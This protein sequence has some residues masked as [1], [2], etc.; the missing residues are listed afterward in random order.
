MASKNYES[1]IQSKGVDKAITVDDIATDVF[2]TGSSITFKSVWNAIRACIRAII[3]RFDDVDTDIQGA[4][5]TLALTNPPSINGNWSCTQKLT[6]TGLT[7]KYTR[8]FFAFYRK[9]SESNVFGIPSLWT[10]NMPDVQFYDQCGAHTDRGFY[11][12]SN[13]SAY[14]VGT[15]NVTREPSVRLRSFKVQSS[16]NSNDITIT[17]ECDGYN[18]SSSSHGIGDYELRYA[19]F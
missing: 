4:Q 19:L 16:S 2:T 6:I 3:H 14:F 12:Q 8:G 7:R 18:T 13:A 10:E 15:F 9:G 1:E 17:F 11:G 5:G